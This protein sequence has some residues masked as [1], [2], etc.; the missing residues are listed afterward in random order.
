MYSASNAFHDAV[1]SGAHQIALLIFDDLVFAGSDIDVDA[2]IEF[3]DYFNTETDLSIGQAPSNEL[4]FSVFNENDLLNDYAFG[5]F[6]ATIGVQ[7]DSSTVTENGTIQVSSASHSYVANS[8]S[9]YLTRDGS[10]V[11]SQPNGEIQSILIYDGYVYCYLKNDSVYVYKDSNGSRRSSMDLNDFMKNQMHKWSGKGI[12]YNKNTRKLY[13]YE[14]TNRR[15]YEFVPLGYFTA[16]RPNVPD[17]YKLDF[18]CYDFMQK[19]EDD[20]PSNSELNITFPCTIATLFTKM[21]NYLNVSYAS[22]SFINSTATISE[23]PD[24]FDSATMRDVLKWIAEAAGSNAKFNRDGELVMD[25]LH[26]TDTEIDESGYSDLSPTWYTTGQVTKLYN[27]ASDGSYCNTVGSGSEA[28]L[29][30]DNPLL[31]GVS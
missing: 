14:G 5:D 30:Q 25:W 19:F 17:V 4:S 29:I 2:G 1:E 6:L 31:K 24:D 23:R 26:S 8:T 11:S 18:T 9:P 21:C 15:I 7:I 13:I 20:M 12:F 16:D 27:Q 22:S 28:Y 3:H 10:A